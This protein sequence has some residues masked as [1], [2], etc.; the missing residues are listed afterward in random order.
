[1][2]AP[3]GGAIRREATKAASEISFKFAFQFIVTE[4]IVLGNT[5][6]PGP[7]RNDWGICGGSGS[8]VHNKTRPTIK[9][10]GG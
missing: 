2:T 1:M 10:E 8:G 9:A 7:S 3:T 6:S 5:A 4:M